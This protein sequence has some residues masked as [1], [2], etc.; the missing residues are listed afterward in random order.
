MAQKALALI[1]A[2]NDPLSFE[3]IDGSGEK[4][5]LK[6]D[7]LSGISQVELEFFGL[8]LE[9]PARASDL[10]E[11]LE[12]ATKTAVSVLTK[13]AAARLVDQHLSGVPSVWRVLAA[14]KNSAEP[15]VCLRSVFG[16]QRPFEVATDIYAKRL[17]DRREDFV[18]AYVVRQFVLFLHFGFS[19]DT[20]Y[21]RQVGRAMTEDG[22]SLLKWEGQSLMELCASPSPWRE[23]SV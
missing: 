22:G 8:T 13:S 23:A 11:S 4:L 17:G 2:L 5:G 12:R 19:V 21:T 14:P 20:A 3:H 9:Q 6:P 16:E 1:S 7:C 10:L 15:T 18:V